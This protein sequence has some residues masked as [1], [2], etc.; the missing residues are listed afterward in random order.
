MGTNDVNRKKL[1][2]GTE[3][4]RGTHVAASR[5]I[6]ADFTHAYDRPIQEFPDRSGTYFG[7][8]RV[9]YQRPNISFSATDL[10]TF[11]DI[12]YWLLLSISGAPV[13][14]PD[15]GAPTPAQ[16]WV[17]TPHATADD[18]KSWTIE[19]NEPGNVYETSQFM[20]NTLTIRVDPDNDGAWM[21]DIAG[22]GRDWDTSTY[23][24]AL[25]ER[26]TEAIFAAGT[27][28]FL[29]TTTIGTTQALGQVIDF[30]I[31]VTLNTHM[32][33]FMENV[34][35]WAANRVGRGYRTFDATYSLEF[36]NDTEFA[37]YR[38]ATAVKRKVRVKRSG[39]EIHATPSVLNSAQID[40]YGYYRSIGFG[41]REGNLIATFGL[42][43]FYDVA[44]LTDAKFTIINSLT[45][46][47]LV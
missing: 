24:A 25:P 8:R 44:A 40:I 29:D 20:L 7:R 45:A 30:S 47:L 32:K 38:S 4:V 43:G 3:T 13:I 14:T 11:E 35:V 46:L 18:I 34:G 2:S 16:T 36:D 15:A 41:D 9:A 17:F 26:T 12:C 6:Y 21:A 19:F 31:T 27:E 28:F 42:A 5:I 33:A 37:L 10:L 23:T 39:S 22:Y 1:Q